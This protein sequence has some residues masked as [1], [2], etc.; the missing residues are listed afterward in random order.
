MDTA[1]QARKVRSELFNNHG[2][3]EEILVQCWP[4]S[5]KKLFMNQKYKNKVLGQHK[6]GYENAEF[7]SF[8]YYKVK[9]ANHNY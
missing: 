6:D 5:E 4:L 8:I 2:W 7:W 3:L 9:T 1:N